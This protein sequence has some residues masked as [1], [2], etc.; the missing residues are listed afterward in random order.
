MSKFKQLQHVLMV[1]GTHR[2]ARRTQQHH[3][4]PARQPNARGHHGPIG[5]QPK[6]RQPQSQIPKANGYL[7]PLKP[8]GELPPEDSFNV[9]LHRQEYLSWAWGG[10]GL[11]DGKS[12]KEKI[13]DG[14]DELQ[15]R[16]L[17]RRVEQRRLMS[18]LS[19]GFLRMYLK[20][21][22][23]DELVQA[24]GD[25]IYESQKWKEIS[26]DIAKKLQAH[27]NAHRKEPTADE[28]GKAHTDELNKR[29]AT[30][31]GFR[32]A[33]ELNPVVGGAKGKITRT[34]IMARRTVG[35]DTILD[36]QVDILVYDTY[37]FDNDR[38]DV[39][40]YDHYRKNLARLL[41]N[42]DFDGFES[43]FLG[44]FMPLKPSKT[45]LDHAALFA[46]FMYALEMRRWTPGGLSWEVTVPMIGS[47][48]APAP[49][50]VPA[51]QPPRIK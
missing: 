38:S 26:T 1:H 12:T 49:R 23:D 8:R 13:Q 6:Q 5:T 10:S 45:S 34:T 16:L 51:P 11:M 36:Y 21:E 29:M 40:E 4:G 47:I 2:L 24:A 25:Q 7:P 50:G 41:Q 39:P 14:L 48:T 18:D 31:E 15:R 35:N 3:H 19:G 44:E 27:V 17:G 42:D 37:D 46:S 30:K 43:S 32:F 9:F 33:G 28:I 22:V 20:H